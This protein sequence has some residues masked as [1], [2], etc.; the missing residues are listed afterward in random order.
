MVTLQAEMPSELMKEVLSNMDKKV[1][2]VRWQAQKKMDDPDA[3]VPVQALSALL[4]E[5]AIWFD[6][7]KHPVYSQALELLGGWMRSSQMK[8]KE[9]AVLCVMMKL[10]ELLVGDTELEWYQEPFATTKAAAGVVFSEQNQATIAEAVAALAEHCLSSMQETELQAMVGIWLE[11]MGHGHRG[12]QKHLVLMAPLLCHWLALPR[13]K[14]IARYLAI[15]VKYK[16]ID[17]SYA[18]SDWMSSMG[19]PL[20][21]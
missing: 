15:P 13:I 12:F 21:Y 18:C 5:A 16:A 11:I 6:G 2:D 14:H 10:P 8:Q 7:S 1:L 19:A 3:L 17:Y 20:S 4:A 9:S